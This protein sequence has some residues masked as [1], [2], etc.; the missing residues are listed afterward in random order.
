MA[1]D[2][3]KLSGRIIEMCGTQQAFSRKMGIS[4]HSISKKLNS[5]YFWKQ[6]EIKKACEILEI[7][8]SEIPDYFFT[9]KVQKI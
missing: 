9:E 8:V 3:S 5:K 2:Y 7:A 1:F 4:E 6:Q